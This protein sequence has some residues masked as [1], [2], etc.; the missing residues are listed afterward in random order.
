MKKIMLICLLLPVM[1]LAQDKDAGRYISMT[2]TAELEVVPDRVVLRMSVNE[3]ERIRRESDVAVMEKNI[4]VF[5]HNLGIGKESFTIEGIMAGNGYLF[6]QGS[7]YNLFKSYLLRLEKPELLD[8]IVRSCFDFGIESIRIEAMEHTKIDSLKN[9]VLVMALSAAHSKAMLAASTLGVSLGKV[10]TISE[11]DWVQSPLGG[12]PN[13]TFFS[14]RQSKIRAGGDSWYSQGES[15]PGLNK[16]TLSKSVL[17]R[18]EM[19]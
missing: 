12:E 4:L 16:I 17:V 14:Y 6:T 13:M 15:T 11:D 1:V 7:R 19:E 18:W 3:T 10:V 5:L 9:E 8:T 2:G